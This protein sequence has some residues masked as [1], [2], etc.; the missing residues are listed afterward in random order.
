M[1]DKRGHHLSLELVHDAPPLRIRYRPGCGERMVLAFSGVG[2][3]TDP[4]SE[5]ALEFFRSASGGGANHVLHVTDQSR[6]WLNAAGMAEAIADTARRML[7]RTGARRLAAVGNSMGG[8]MALLIAR[9]LPV[10]RV[11]A[12][13]PQY[14]VDAGIVPEEGKWKRLRRMIG[15]F[16]FPAVDR[17]APAGEQFILHGDSDEELVHALRFPAAPNLHHFIFTGHGHELGEDL[18]ASGATARLVEAGLAGTPADFAAI[19]RAAGGL[20][21]TEYER[22]RDFRPAPAPRAATL[23]GDRR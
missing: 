9:F 18:K 19:A 1:E 20:D 23:Q 5:P 6:S 3:T 4:D 12:F 16:R 8:T 15:D 7:A 10:D 17:I 21:R 11:V 13:V 22:L 2:Q 14:S